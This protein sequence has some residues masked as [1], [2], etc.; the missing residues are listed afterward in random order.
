MTAPRYH[1]WQLRLEAFIRERSSVPFA[2]GS[3][4]CASFAADAVRALTGDRLLPALRG[5]TSVREALGAL[6]HA[7]GLSGIATMALGGPLSP[8]V[9]NVG[10]VVLVRIG[11]RDALGVCNGGTVLGPGVSGVVAVPMAQALRCWRVG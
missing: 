11:K 1:D 6:R 5:Y 4:D 10:D 7:G 8:R 3:N 2:W 9:A